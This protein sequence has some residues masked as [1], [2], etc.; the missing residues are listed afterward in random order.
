M[1]SQKILTPQEA[2]RALA[3]NQR[4]TSNNWGTGK[5]IYLNERGFIYNEKR[6]LCELTDAGGLCLYTEP[7]PRKKVA[8]YYV[9]YKDIVD[10]SLVDLEQR[11][12]ETD[13]EAKEFYDAALS[14]RHCTALEIEV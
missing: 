1:T 10:N 11:C 12:F 14:V 5:Y 7:K 8:P 6:V 13:E 2:L 9:T 3:D 4:L